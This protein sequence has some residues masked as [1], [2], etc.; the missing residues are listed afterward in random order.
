MFKWLATSDE[1]G[2]NKREVSHQ[3]GLPSVIHYYLVTWFQEET[4][5][6]CDQSTVIVISG[7]S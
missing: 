5:V 2:L 1:Y 3:G 6:L 7:Q 4:W